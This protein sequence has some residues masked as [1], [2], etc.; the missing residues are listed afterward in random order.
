MKR[1]FLSALAMFLI[2]TAAQAQFGYT[3]TTQAGQA[4]TPLTTGSTNLTA[5]DQW[6]D[7][8]WSAPLGFSF[9]LAGRSLTAVDIV[10][11]FDDLLV[12]RLVQSANDTFTGF[13]AMDGDLHDRGN[14]TSGF[15]A[16]SPIR[17]VTTG[18]APS[19]IFKLE[20]ANAGFAFNFNNTDSINFQ[21][22]L[23]EGSNVVELRY[24]S[25]RVNPNAFLLY[26]SS[27][28][29][30]S[31]GYLRNLD[32]SGAAAF[33]KYYYL[34]GPAATPTVD[35]ATLPTQP[36]A[37]LTGYPAAGTVYRFGPSSTGIN[38]TEAMAAARSL[39]LYPTAAT[40]AIT[41]EWAG[42][43]GEAYEIISATGQQVAAGRL[44][45]G[46]QDIP[47]SNLA[48]GTYHLRLAAGSHAF[49][50]Q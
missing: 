23:Y 50:K 14:P 16:L 15:D 47:V 46:T 24:G 25:S 3:F 6:D 8:E 9:M 12:G 36:T 45:R 19:R 38:L 2:G 5:N 4:Y 43:A 49:V 18:T 22:W 40:T 34:R 20:F 17:Y 29:G 1:L 31:L 13:K 39:K 41:V 32:Y 42:T 37:V 30:P 33:G 26:F 21:V 35:T 10:A 48:A 28:T 44:Q 11:N 27:S 7:D